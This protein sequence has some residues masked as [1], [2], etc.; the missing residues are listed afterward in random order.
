ME[1]SKQKQE[2]EIKKKKEQPKYVPIQTD[3]NSVESAKIGEVSLSSEVLRADRLLSLLV[4]ALQNEDVKKYL[5]L[6]E[7]KKGASYYG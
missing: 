7:K 4:G 2:G 1:Q 5:G 3:F 6:I